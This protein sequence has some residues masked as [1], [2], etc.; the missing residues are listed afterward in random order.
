M[1][2]SYLKIAKKR[3][4]KKVTLEDHQGDNFRRVKVTKY[5]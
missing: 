5:S 4:H 3:Q 1:K 2:R